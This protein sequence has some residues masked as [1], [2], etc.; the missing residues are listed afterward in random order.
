MWPTRTSGLVGKLVH[1][2][3]Q[4]SHRRLLV[5]RVVAVKSAFSDGFVV[6][7]GSQAKL[8][9]GTSLVTSSDELTE[10]AVL[11]VQARTDG[12]VALTGLFVCLDALF[13][14]LNVCHGNYLFLYACHA[15]GAHDA[16]YH[17][18]SCHFS[19]EE[20]VEG[21]TRASAREISP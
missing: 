3:E 12:L 8:S 17:N 4:L 5:R 14:G 9:L 11:G 15:L 7:A 2:V 6:L 18:S 10:L 13:L 19:C 20:H 21:G 16:I 1:R